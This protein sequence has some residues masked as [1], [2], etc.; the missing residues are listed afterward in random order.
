MKNARF[1]LSL[2]LLA[3]LLNGCSSD[4]FGQSA[5]KLSKEISLPNVKGRIDHMDA[6]VQNQVIFVA[7]LGNNTVEVA[8]LETGKV[9]HTITGLSEPQGLAYIPKHHELFVAN[10][11][12]G[13]CIFYNTANWQKIASVKYYNDA[14][15]ARY[16][17]E[18]DQVY[19]GYGSGGIG[20]IDAAT[21]KKIAD[22][23]LPAHPESFQLDTKENR[24]WVN[25]PNSG[26]IGV[27]DIKQHKL[28]EKWKH[29]L[30][31]ANFPMAYDAAQHRVIVGYRVPATLKVLDSN[32]GKEI[33]SS[34][35][36]GD[37]DDLYWDDKTKQIIVS[38]GSGSVN[39]FKQTGPATYKE[40]AN[41]PTRDGARTSLWVPELRLFI[42]A[43]R[44]TGGHEATL[45]IYK[46]AD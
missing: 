34:G 43:A 4:S 16:D 40:I 23:P 17:A 6:D 33:F 26:M 44:S 18:A 10:G 8:D 21:H 3:V 42:L 9:L 46:L 27:V 22:I 31:R 12:T 11:G 13:E 36:A 35:M 32:T 15:D 39:I 5:L 7:A 30:P 19:V 25:L 37:A 28:V 41:I 14:D 2:I 24:L 1:P 29:I 38:G 20:I 45:L